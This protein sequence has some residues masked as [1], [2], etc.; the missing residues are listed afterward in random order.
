MDR[1][2]AL[3]QDAGDLLDQKR[4]ED[5]LDRVLR[6]EELYHAPTHLLMMGEAQ[7][8]LRRLAAAADTYERLVAEPLPPGAPAA[9]RNAQQ[10]ARTRLTAL[11]QRLPSL[12][13]RVHGTPADKVKATVDG[14]PVDLRAGVAVRLDPGRHVVRLTADGYAPLEHA[15]VMPDRGGVVVVDLTF[16][17]GAAAAVAPRPPPSAAPAVQSGST[18]P[19]RM[20]AWVAFGVGGAGLLVG[21]ITG[22]M[23]LGKVGGIKDRCPDGRCPPGEQG[24]IDSARTLGN[25]STVGFVIGGIGAATGAV[26]L[27][28]AP[29]SGGREKPP[30]AGPRVVPWIGLASGGVSAQF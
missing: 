12:L 30:A 25:V 3:A 8:G 16:S 1:A 27:F 9:F 21:T 6:A 28:A 23:A 18:G 7:E 29:G 26:L 4:Y 19:T 13:V 14:R 24:E 10:T 20:P 17:G 2:R 22:A 15:E 5:A 11:A